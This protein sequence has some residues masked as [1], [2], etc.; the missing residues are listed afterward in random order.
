MVIERALEDLSNVYKL[1]NII[2]RYFN[3]A[4]GDPK[5][6][7]G[8][9]HNPETHLIPL[10]LQTISGKRANFEIYGDD[11]PTYDSTCIDFIHVND[12]AKAHILGLKKLFKFLR[13]KD[14]IKSIPLNLGN[15]IGYSIKE[16]IQVAEKIAGKSLN[17][18]V[19]KEEGD[20]PELIASST[21]A[22]ELLKWTPQSDDL[23]TIIKD[24][25]AWEKKLNSFY[26]ES[27][28]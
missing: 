1:P 19:S 6:R 5:A 2:F 10:I 27:S 26:E 21:R 9:N 25:W 15:D 22:R 14:N 17:Y 13:E 3:A 18:K 8:E 7:I 24:A 12:L 4:G 23:E 28:I 11:Y 16:V 20:P